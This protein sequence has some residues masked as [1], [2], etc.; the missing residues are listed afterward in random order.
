MN[1]YTVYYL[2]MTKS[3]VLL[4]VHTQGKP[5]EHYRC[6][7]ISL[8]G[9]L[10]F[11]QPLTYQKRFFICSDLCNIDSILNSSLKLPILREIILTPTEKE[12]TNFTLNHEYTYPI[13]QDLKSTVLTNIRLYLLD[14]TGKNVPLDHCHLQCTLLTFGK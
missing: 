14:D 9:S 8:N 7:L 3:D 10:A 1:Q 2:E 11:T 12:Q 6:G 5:L 13:W 4:P